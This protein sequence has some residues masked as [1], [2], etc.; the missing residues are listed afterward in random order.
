[1]NA[2]DDNCSPA[3]ILADTTGMTRTDIVRLV[4]G[5]RVDGFQFGC[6]Y[7]VNQESLSAYIEAHGL[8]A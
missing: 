2:Y 3:S 1:M 6:D 8:T 5:R 7:H 4:L